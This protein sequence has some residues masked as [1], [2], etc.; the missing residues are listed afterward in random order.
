MSYTS[1]VHCLGWSVLLLAAL[2]IFPALT[3][4]LEGTPQLAWTFGASAV[5]SGFFG[6]GF[7]LATRQSGGNFGKREAFMF[8]VLVWLV[9]AFLEL[10]H[11]IFRAFPS[12]PSMP[13][14]N[15]FRA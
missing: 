12:I 3:A 5:L 4:M 10:S 9:L 1:V 6:G 8:L 14:L 7:A 2:M 13:I 15:L 11:F